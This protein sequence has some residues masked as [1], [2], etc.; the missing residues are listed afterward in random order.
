MVARLGFITPEDYLAIERKAEHKSEYIDGVMYAMAGASESHNLIVMNIG[1]RLS[2]QLEKEP[3]K[4]YPSDLKVCVSDSL[5]FFYPD[6][7]VVCGE[8]KFIDDKRDVLLNPLLIVEVLSESAASFDHGRKFRYYQE[9]ESFQEYLLV[10]QDEP[11]VERFVRRADGSWIYTKVEGL[12][13][14]VALSSIDCRIIL[15]DIYAKVL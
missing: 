1:T 8:A 6:L 14:T 12:D 10:A 9:I 13:E 3:C 7:T 15:K 5:K 4:V 11:V 2:I